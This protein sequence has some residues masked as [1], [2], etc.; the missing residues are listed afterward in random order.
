M[1]IS[2]TLG[3][4]TVHTSLSLE[5]ST[6]V[7]S[8]LWLTALCLVAPATAQSSDYRADEAVVAEVLAPVLYSYAALMQQQTHRQ[9]C[10]QVLTSQRDVLVHEHN[11]KPWLLRHLMPLVGAAM[12][13]VVGGLVLKRHLSAQAAKHWAIPVITGSGAAGF[14]A[15]PGGVSGFVVGGAIGGKIGKQKLPITVGSAA[16]G[17][18][19]G[20][21]LWDTVFPPDVPPAPGDEPSDD[22]PVEVF[23]R[24][25]VCSTGVQAAYEQS[26]YR[27]GYRFNDQDLVADLPYDPGEAL[28]LSA[29]GNITGPA[30]LR[31]D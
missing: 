12:G 8:A 9:I 30:R 18:L 14:W 26:V 6:L 28:R 13:G 16:G 5:T 25:Q 4:L 2:K 19:I 31:L 20:K 1:D 29:S 17:T 15:G 10:W 3:K 22:I 7:K 27:V 24:E 21:M 23:V 11:A